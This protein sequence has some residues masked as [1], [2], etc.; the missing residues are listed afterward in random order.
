[1]IRPRSPVQVKQWSEHDSKKPK[2]QPVKTENSEDP[3]RKCW[4]LRD[5]ELY[6]HRG[7]TDVKGPHAESVG[8]GSSPDTN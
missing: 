3:D 7:E 4:I 6:L 1:M 2:D 5:K 8:A